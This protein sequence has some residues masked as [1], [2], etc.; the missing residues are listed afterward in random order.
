MN[1]KEEFLKQLSL[2]RNDM[3]LLALSLVRNDADAGDV[4]SEAIYRA[5][6][7]MDKL[8][9]ASAFKPWI[10]RIVHNAAV[11]MIRKNARLL[12]QDTIDSGESEGH[13][14]RIVT[15]MALWEAVGQLKQ[16]YRTVVI[17]FYYEELPIAQ[18]AGITKSSPGA[19]KKQI[20]RARAMLR[21]LLKEEFIHE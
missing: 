9:K 16:P 11:E 17:L 8:K 2:Y 1:D 4:I 19:V 3:Y 14:N 15:K 18:I 6:N 20:S 7:N 12:P 5:Y 21:E 10:L 13:E